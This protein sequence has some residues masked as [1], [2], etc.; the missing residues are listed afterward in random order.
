MATSTDLCSSDILRTVRG[1]LTLVIACFCFASRRLPGF[2]LRVFRGWRG[3]FVCEHLVVC[4]RGVFA[5]LGD[6]QRPAAIFDGSSGRMREKRGLERSDG[7]DVGHPEP[8][9]QKV[10][11]LAR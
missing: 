4:V 8:K 7:E 11:A 1:T 5:D 9:K 2:V 6:M 3:V 10:P